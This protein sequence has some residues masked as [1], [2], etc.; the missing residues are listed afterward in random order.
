MADSSV[1]SG[2][3]TAHGPAIRVKVSGPIGTPP[4]RTV[5]RLVW[6]SADT[7]LYGAV[8]RLVSAT[9]VRPDDVDGLQHRLLADH[10][11]DRAGDAAA[12]EG[13]AAVHLDLGDHRVDVGLGCGTRAI[14]ITMTAKLL[15]DRQ[16]DR[17]RSRSALGY[18]RA[19]A[20]LDRH[21]VAAMKSNRP[22]SFL[23]TLDL[24]PEVSSAPWPRVDR[25]PA[26]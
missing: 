26:R 11:D 15:D 25:R 1:C 19:R 2:V 22:L 18:H 16:H 3:S 12:D 20:G 13:L 10:A 21:P 24:Q 17:E 7:S 8:I 5:L 6:L 4:T 14:T 23:I 9:P